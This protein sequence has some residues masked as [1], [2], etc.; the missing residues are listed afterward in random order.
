MQIF[1]IEGEEVGDL[2]ALWVDYAESVAFLQGESCASARYEFDDSVGEDM[3]FFRHVE[4]TNAAEE[5]SVQ[6]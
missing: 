3:C 5:Q 6:C 2:H 4:I 1:S